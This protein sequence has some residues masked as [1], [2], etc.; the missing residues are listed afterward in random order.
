MSRCSTGM[1][2]LALELAP[3]G[4]TVNAIA[5]GTIETDIADGVLRDPQLRPVI[6]ATISLGRTGHVYELK[7]LALF[8]ASSASNFMT[9]VHIMVDGGRTLM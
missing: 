9:G 5:P 7:G 8:P 4:I 1:R 2:N 6:G 3:H